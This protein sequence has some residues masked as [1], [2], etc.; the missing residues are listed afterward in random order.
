MSVFASVARPFVLIPRVVVPDLRNFLVLG[1]R[2]L[3]A[4]LL[5][6][7]ICVL[8]VIYCSALLPAWALSVMSGS[9]NRAGPGGAISLLLSRGRTWIRGGRRSTQLRAVERKMPRL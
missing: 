2:L 3:A 5:M 6:P 8:L 7:L 9:A 1:G 4:L